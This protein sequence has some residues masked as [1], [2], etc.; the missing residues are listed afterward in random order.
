MRNNVKDFIDPDYL[1]L[2][3]KEWN[4]SVSVPKDMS[5]E[6][7]HERKLIKVSLSVNSD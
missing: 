5:I 4:G 2:R 6:E 3:K 1:G 7:S